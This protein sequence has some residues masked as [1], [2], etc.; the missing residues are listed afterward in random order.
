M[1]PDKPNTRPRRLSSCFSASELELDWPAV[2]YENARRVTGLQIQDV[3]G[4]LWQVREARP[5]AH[6]FDLLLGYPINPGAGKKVWMNLN[7]I[8]PTRAL[9]DYFHEHRA[10]TYANFNLPA[11]QSSLVA[12]RRKLGYNFDKDRQA[13]WRERLPDLKSL[14]P[15][16]FAKRYQVSREQAVWWRR[17]LVGSNERAHHWWREPAVLELLH[18]RMSLSK[19]AEALGISRSYACQLRRQAVQLNRA[20]SFSAVPNAETEP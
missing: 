5:T 19:L 8:V 4:V 16:E 2:S 14:T 20:R 9:A 12:V 10:D 17:T 11:T 7:R 6:G 18:S 15:D 1:H 3:E 13:I